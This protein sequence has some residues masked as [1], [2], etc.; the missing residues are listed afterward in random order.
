[1]NRNTPVPI[2][3]VIGQHINLESCQMVQLIKA[4]VQISEKFLQRNRDRLWLLHRGQTAS[5]SGFYAP[6]WGRLQRLIA[7]RDLRIQH[8]GF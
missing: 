7:L 3:R 2:S 8:R 1:M 4:A 6:T 5:D